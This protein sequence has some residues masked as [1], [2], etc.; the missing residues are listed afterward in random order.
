MSILNVA[1]DQTK[2]Y[3]TVDWGI[4]WLLKVLLVEIV[5]IS[6]PRG[7]NGQ[8][9]W[10]CDIYAYQW[11]VIIVFNFPYVCITFVMQS[12]N[13]QWRSWEPHLCCLP[14]FAT[15]SLSIHTTLQDLKFASV[16]ILRIPEGQR[17]NKLITHKERAYDTLQVVK[18]ALDKLSHKKCR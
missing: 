6:R 15:N 17:L 7:R 5:Q 3:T 2:M 4:T 18:K 10:H 9:R 11:D 1:A 12:W 16:A 8:P 13:K 14:H